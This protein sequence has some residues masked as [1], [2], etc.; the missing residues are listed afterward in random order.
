[1]KGNT[2]RNNA[3]VDIFDGSGT[4]PANSYVDNTCDTSSP[5]NLCEN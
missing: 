2:A 4:P 3:G 1:V 5:N